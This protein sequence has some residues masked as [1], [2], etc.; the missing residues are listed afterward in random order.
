MKKN[1]L[2]FSSTKK[3]NDKKS[4]R[5]PKQLKL[6]RV[7]SNNQVTFATIT[8]EQAELILQVEQL[9]QAVLVR[10]RQAGMGQQ[11]WQRHQHHLNVGIVKPTAMSF[12]VKPAMKN[13]VMLIRKC[14][15]VIRQRQGYI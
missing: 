14:E 7:L 9:I 8:Q 2:F 6:P 11:G 3:N 13:S 5:R 1:N 15:L 10:E 4:A 12:V